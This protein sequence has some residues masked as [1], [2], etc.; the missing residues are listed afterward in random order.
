MARSKYHNPTTGQW[1]YADNN[2]LP[3]G[4]DGDILVNENGVW[5]AKPITDVIPNGGG[6]LPKMTDLLSIT[7]TRGE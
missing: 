2:P 1:E 5:V 4:E 6:G 3:T 7:M